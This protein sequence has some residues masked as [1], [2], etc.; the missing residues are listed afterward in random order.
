[1]SPQVVNILTLFFLFKVS[2]IAMA[3]VLWWYAI[4]ALRKHLSS[5]T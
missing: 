1:M 2:G 3:I 5:K 4:A